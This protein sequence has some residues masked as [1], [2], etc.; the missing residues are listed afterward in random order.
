MSQ[1]GDDM[2][3]VG[4]MPPTQEDQI[5]LANRGYGP[6]EDGQ[7]GY[8]SSTTTTVQRTMQNRTH[9]TVSTEVRPHTIDV[10]PAPRTRW[11]AP[12]SGHAASRHALPGKGGSS[13][14]QGYRGEGGLRMEY[15]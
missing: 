15:V 1:G 9:K 14:P 3:D 7:W 10:L 6:G 8:Q 12:A 2:A 5:A 11:P 13:I 4:G